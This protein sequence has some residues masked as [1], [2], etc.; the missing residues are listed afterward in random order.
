MKE[1]KMGEKV[2]KGGKDAT[3]G[4]AVNSPLS[5]VKR[6]ESAGLIERALN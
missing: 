3:Q 6:Q 5:K 2:S 4:F 1:E